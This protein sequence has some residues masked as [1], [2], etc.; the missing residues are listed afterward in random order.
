MAVRNLALDADIRAV[1]ERELVPLLPTVRDD[2]VRYRERW[3]RYYRIWSIQHDQQGYRGRINTYFP[4][5]RRWIENWVKRVKRD[6]FPDTD[7]FGCRALREEFERRVPGKVAL[8]RYW[9]RRHMRLRRHATPW[10]RQLVM[11]GSS[12]VRNVW[13]VDERQMT[14]LRDVMSDDGTPSGRTMEQVEKLVDYLGPTFRPVDLFAWYL[15][16]TTCTD[17]D[18]AE[19]VFEDL[20]VSRERLQALAKTPLDPNDDKAGH[21]YE[22]VGELLAQ[23]DEPALR[24]D[25][26][27]GAVEKFDALARRLAD[28]GFTHPLDTKLPLSMR[29]VDITECAWVRD[30]GEGRKKY[31]VAIGGD[32]V[33]LR[34]QDMP[35]WHGGTPWLCGKFVE[36]L[37]EFYGRGLPET[38]DHIQYFVND[39][40]NQAADALVWSTTPMAKIDMG[41]VQDPTSLRMVPGAKWLVS[42]GGVEF[43]QPPQGAAQAGFAGMSTIMGI[44]NEL[45]SPTPAGGLGTAPRGRGR[46]QQTAAGTQILLTENAV[47]LREV[48][49]NLEDQVMNRLLERN[50]LLAQQFLDRAVT[51]KIAGADGIALMDTPITVAD[52]VGEYEYEWLGSLAALNQQVRAKQMLDGMALLLKLPPDQLAR[53]N[54]AVSWK[55]L[56]RTYWRDGLGLRDAELVLRDRVKERAT[57]WRLENALFLA[58]RGEDV[59]VSPSEPHIEHVRGHVKVRGKLPPEFQAMLDR[60]VQEHIAAAVAAEVMQLQQQQQQE[61]AQ[62]MPP[63]GPAGAPNGN[64]GARPPAPIGPGRMASTMGVDDLFR[65]LPREG[66]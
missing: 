6:L 28:K 56:I 55:H 25:G 22:R 44:G 17:V 3:L 37:S 47:D 58:S 51:L 64:G 43:T 10:L 66:L 26:G 62:L 16:P 41:A 49:E 8:Q 39:I 63:G 5:G 45:V 27:S 36:V 59:R 1:A 33:V 57:D 65:A 52:L 31:L 15:W 50:D 13:R 9:F 19:L 23:Y 34:I 21:V 53:E 14:V 54:V 35:F 32:T 42:A 29:P 12:P 46:S 48:V 40:G 24:K 20:L 18:D 2:R 7:W 61:Q 4:I 60:H 38:F 11:L 30:L